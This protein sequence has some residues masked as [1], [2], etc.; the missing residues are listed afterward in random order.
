MYARTSLLH[1]DLSISRF[2]NSCQTLVTG[3]WFWQILLGMVWRRRAHDMMGLSIVPVFT[4]LLLKNHDSR[5]WQDNRSWEGNEDLSNSS[6]K[7]TE[8][9]SCEQ[10]TVRGSWNPDF[11]P[12]AWLPKVIFPASQGQVERL[13]LAA[14]GKAPWVSVKLGALGGSKLPGWDQQC[15]LPKIKKQCYLA[16]TKK[17]WSVN[18]RE[19]RNCEGT[20][21]LEN[22]QVLRNCFRWNCFLMAH[23]Q[24][25]I[26]SKPCG[27]RGGSTVESYS[28]WS[29]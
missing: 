20:N 27:Y 5:P 24:V 9:T 4:V 2:F 17:K 15:F 14:N 23:S 8:Y 13:H 18:F 12:W 7:N 10:C 16:I 28:H 3:W 26:L 29:L 22:T 21:I 1:P 11:C 6:C 19:T 25:G